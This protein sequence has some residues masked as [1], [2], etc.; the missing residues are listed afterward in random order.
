MLDRRNSV[1]LLL[2]DRDN[3]LVVAGLGSAVYDVYAAGDHPLNFYDWGA[4]GSAAMVGL[5]L[6]LARP[7]WP[8]CV[9]T[10]DGEMLMGLGTFATIA[11]HKPANL[12]IIILDNGQYAETG[13]QDSATSHGADLAAIARA[14]GLADAQTISDPG[15]LE[16][17]RAQLHAHAGP[18]VGVLKVQCGSVSRT[19]PIKDGVAI[20]T[21]FAQALKA[22]C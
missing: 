18:F 14:S 7:D 9:F 19:I 20:K 11:Q 12:S 10:G 21:R 5:G 3:M 17:L 8:V 13:M 6:A 1:D 2:Q 15:E 16:A 4:M 22:R